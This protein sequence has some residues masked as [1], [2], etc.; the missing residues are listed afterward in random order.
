MIKN[1]DITKNVRTPSDVSVAQNVGQ[2]RD[3]GSQSPYRLG[4]QAPGIAT[5][6]LAGNPD[7]T[8][9]AQIESLFERHGL[10]VAGAGDQHDRARIE[11]VRDP[12]RQ[13]R[14]GNPPGCEERHAVILTPAHVRVKDS[15]KGRF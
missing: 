3:G 9:L 10:S 14:P 2:A 15:F 7:R 12:S 8:P 6:L 4:Q 11:P 1:P 13:S 5:S